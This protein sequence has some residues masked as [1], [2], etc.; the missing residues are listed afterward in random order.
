[1]MKRTLR[2]WK[3]GYEGGVAGLCAETFCVVIALAFYV[4]NALIPMQVWALDSA[5]REALVASLP[6]GETFEND[7]STYLFLP[8]IQAVRTTPESMGSKGK[9]AGVSDSKGIEIKGFIER[10]G[11][12]ALYRHSFSEASSI[13]FERGDSE[14]V[15]VSPVVLNL[16]TG[17][18]TVITGKMCL[19]LNDLEDVKDLA[20]AYGI[21]LSF[22]NQYLTLA[23]YEIPPDVEIL[24]LR[25]DLLNDPRVLRVTLDM[26]D[27]IRHAH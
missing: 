19:K 15:T 11:L 12:Y 24:V 17:S 22:V 9:E 20:D 18:F 16:R 6:K 4:S 27:R 3:K 7:G 26:V 23:C 2:T 5:G 1:M 10:K 25:K 21:A 13:R 8:T 14:D